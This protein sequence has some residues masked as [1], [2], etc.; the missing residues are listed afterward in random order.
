LESV[1]SNEDDD[2]F[3]VE[4]NEEE[5][6]TLQKSKAVRTPMNKALSNSG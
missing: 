2:E 5:P 4:E 1:F 3:I 6:E